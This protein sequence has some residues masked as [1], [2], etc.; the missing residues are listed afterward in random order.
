V[1][2]EQAQLPREQSLSQGKG[3]FLAYTALMDQF[4]ESAM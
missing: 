3:R 4:A 1:Q 2:V